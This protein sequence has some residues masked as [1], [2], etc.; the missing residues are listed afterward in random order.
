MPMK[1]YLSRL[2]LAMAVSFYL[3]TPYLSLYIDKANRYSF[4]WTRWDLGSLLFCIGMVGTLFFLSF[5]LLYLRGNRFARKT[6]EFTFVAFCGIALIANM[7]QLVRSHVKDPLTYIFTLGLLAWILL[8]IFM[9]WFVIKHSGKIKKLCMTCCF[10]LSPLI[11]LFTFNALGYKSFISDKGILPLHSERSDHK[12][13]GPGNIYLFIFDEWSYQRTFNDRELIAEFRNLKQL[14]DQSFV[15]HQ[16]RSP[17]S[18]TISSMPSLLFQNNL[19]FHIKTPQLGFQNDE[20]YP[21][22]EKKSIFNHAQG[23]GIYTAMIGSAMP[24]GELLGDSVDFC[25]STC[26]YKRFGDGF[27]DIAGYHLFTGLWMLP[28]PLFHSQRNILKQY[29]FNRFQVNRINDTHKLFQTIVRKQIQPLFAVIHYMI[30]HFPYI[31]TR[32]G[33]KE[34]F[35]VYK[36]EDISNYYGNLAYLDEKIGEIISTLKESNNYTNSLIIMTSDHSWRYDPD[37]D[38]TNWWWIFEKRH[39]PLFIK[40]PNQSRSIQIDTTFKTFMLGSFINKYLDG[41]FTWEEAQIL[42]GKENYFATPSSG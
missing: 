23:L 11:P 8:S 42:F 15:F 19:R 21:L 10:I 37:Y 16:A 9:I 39:V 22:D 25:R 14:A 28:A 40:M 26:V 7:S 4:H 12:V 3:F 32:D 13:N 36:A 2:W 29:Y 35:A 38:K 20:F 41:D 24:Y 18:N 17:G 30:P 31:F 5:M 27:F 1:Y 33:H 34:L 6:F